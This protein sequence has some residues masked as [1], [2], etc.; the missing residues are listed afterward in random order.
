[1]SFTKNKTA[2]NPAGQVIPLM[3][4]Y[5]TDPVNGAE[6][7]EALQPFFIANMSNNFSKGELNH[8][9]KVQFRELI[10]AEIL[11]AQMLLLHEAVHFLGYSELDAEKLESVFPKIPYN[12]EFNAPSD[13]RNY[14]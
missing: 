5:G 6:Y 8:G 1:M 13:C 14:N 12:I 7:V 11:E 9:V 4:S 10:E 3:F 2:T